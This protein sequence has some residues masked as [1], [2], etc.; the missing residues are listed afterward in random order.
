M[1]VMPQ[2]RTATRPAGRPRDVAIDAA[3]L[4]AVSTLLEDSGYSS[5]A[6]ERVARRAGVSKTAV[7]RRWPTR[8]H[9]V[10]AELQ[11]R[12]GHVDAVDTGCTVC[13]LT[14]ALGLFA[15]TFACMGPSFLSALLADCS[16]D[17]DLRQAFMDTLFT[18][19]R[20]VVHA[21]LLR[22]VD[23]GD[24]RPDADLGLVVDSLASMIFYRLLFG[25][26]PVTDDAIG[27]AVDTLLR[28]VACDVDGLRA[29]DVAG[30]HDAAGHASADHHTADRP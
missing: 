26:A 11:R 17:T 27:E 20:Q 7:Y 14:E 28:G 1:A 12:L 18:P 8:Q 10:L 5:L 13:D 30:G 9:L 19:P 22:A 15:G 6:V 2:S 4:D 3:V 25:H 21:T 23:R 16:A 24:L 29:R